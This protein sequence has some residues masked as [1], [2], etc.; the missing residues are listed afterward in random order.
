MTTAPEGLARQ[1]AGEMLVGTVERVTFHNPETG[2]CV[3]RVQVRG[4][5]DLATVVGQAAAITAGERI[6][7]TG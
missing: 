2:F 7:A 4:R 1:H 3:L 5:R 6:Q